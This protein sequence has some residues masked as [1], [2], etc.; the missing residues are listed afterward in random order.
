M[1]PL[2]AIL[3]DFGGVPEFDHGLPSE[4]I[5]RVL[6]HSCE[7]P[8]RSRTDQPLSDVRA[9]TNGRRLRESQRTVSGMVADFRQ[10]VSQLAT[11]CT[12][13]L[14]EPR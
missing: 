5:G 12:A 14:V 11:Q 3:A 6:L 9:K 1:R 10:S 2:A 13:C 7:A 4:M 8:I